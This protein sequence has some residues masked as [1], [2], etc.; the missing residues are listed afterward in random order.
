MTRQ[1]LPAVT[2]E[3]GFNRYLREAWKFPMLTADEEYMLS[4]RWL[5]HGDVDAA[6]RLVTSHLRLVAK[7][8]MEYKG[9]GL[10]IADLVS[11]GSVGLMKAVRKF[12]PERGFRLATYA[13]WWIRASVTEY[14]LH[15]WSLVRTGTLAAQKKLFFSL[16]RVKNQLGIIDNGELTPEDASQLSEA[17]SVSERDV[18][19]MNRRLSARDSSLNLRVGEDGDAEFQDLLPDETPN[20]EML[21]AE[22][23]ESTS[24]Q[25][26]LQRTLGVLPER[27]R[28]ILTERRLSDEP[29]TLE[30]LGQRF[31]ISRER[32]RQL[33][34]R[35]FD[36]LQKAMLEAAPA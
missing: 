10:P 27:E 11:E 29:V 25:A 34:N 3:G 18:V 7:I 20:P 22:R 14:V 24:R 16:R 6:H 28:Q 5:D 1:T 31:G 15:S 23:Q 9:Y 17:L 30:E 26:L 35:A 4:R 2:P 32:V 19:H 36:K 12:D 13:M 8:A 21:M 33:E